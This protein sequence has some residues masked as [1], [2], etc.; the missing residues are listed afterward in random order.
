[1]KVGDFVKRI[2]FQEEDY[3]YWYEHSSALTDDVLELTERNGI[4]IGLRDAPHKIE[5]L[6]NDGEH[7]NVEISLLTIIENPDI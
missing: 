7:E 3:T 4:I 2:S 6:W 5:V 1:M